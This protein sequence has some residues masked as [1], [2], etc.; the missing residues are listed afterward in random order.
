MTLGTLARE[1][2]EIGFIEQ[3]V[4]AKSPVKSSARTEIVRL[5]HVGGDLH[6]CVKSVP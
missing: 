3:S 6:F 1:R 2:L 5:D 4:W